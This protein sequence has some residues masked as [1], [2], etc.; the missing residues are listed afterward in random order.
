MHTAVIWYLTS[1]NKLPKFHFLSLETWKNGLPLECRPLRGESEGSFLPYF[2][3]VSALGI[4]ITTQS[5]PQCSAWK[6]RVQVGLWGWELWFFSGI[7]GGPLWTLRVLQRWAGCVVSLGEEAAL[8]VV[9]ET[10][11]VI[12]R[13][14]SS[15]LY[16]PQP[17]PHPSQP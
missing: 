17:A 11:V 5:M 14:I 13:D 16:A 4:Y 15:Q 6:A 8:Q 9:P 2:I 7:W 3:W 1:P 10:P 12:W